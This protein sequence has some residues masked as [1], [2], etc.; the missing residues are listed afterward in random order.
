MGPTQ[1]SF[2]A[3]SL[4]GDPTCQTPNPTAHCRDPTARSDPESKI[5]RHPLAARNATV[6]PSG[7][8]FAVIDPFFLLIRSIR[9]LVMNVRTLAHH[10]ACP[11]AQCH[12]A[13]VR[14]WWHQRYKR[15]TLVRPPK[16]VFALGLA[17]HTIYAPVASNHDSSPVMWRAQ[18]KMMPERLRDGSHDHVI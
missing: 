6:S 13:P 4:K 16:T 5:T 9:V 17:F 14:R 2:Y 8:V 1:A 11:P 3:D 12:G 15:L 18:N 10:R 7:T